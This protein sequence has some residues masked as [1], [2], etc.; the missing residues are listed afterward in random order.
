MKTCIKKYLKFSTRKMTIWRGNF[1]SIC[2]PG[3]CITTGKMQRKSAKLA[4]LSRASSMTE[5]H[6]TSG[7]TLE[8]SPSGLGSKSMRMKRRSK[9]WLG[10][11]RMSAP[12]GM[13]SASEILHS[14]PP[15][16]ITWNA[17]GTNKNHDACTTISTALVVKVVRIVTDLTH[18]E[19][20]LWLQSTNC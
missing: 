12:S 5:F 19:W 17:S 4:R 13:L 18:H 8:R 11:R 20:G 6:L 16:C 15:I 2:P 10:N 14:R 7:W 3:K 9:G 1:Y